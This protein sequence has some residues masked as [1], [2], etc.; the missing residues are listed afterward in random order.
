LARVENDKCHYA[1]V[2]VPLSDQEVITFLFKSSQEF[3]DKSYL[4]VVRTLELVEKT[5]DPYVQRIH[6]TS[7]SSWNKKTAKAY[8]QY[9]S[10]ES[11]LQWGIF[12]TDAPVNFTELKNIET[13]LDFTFPILLFIQ[14]FWKAE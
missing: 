13:K 6:K 2:E 5:A 10:D 9:F 7:N 8:E 4:D 1:S 11:R 3:S 12:E 14:G